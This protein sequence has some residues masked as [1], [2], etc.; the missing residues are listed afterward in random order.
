MMHKNGGALALATALACACK[1]SGGV[2]PIPE[3]DWQTQRVVANFELLTPW[4]LDLRNPAMSKEMSAVV[5][6]SRFLGHDQGNLTIQA[7]HI[8]YRPGVIANV[9]RSVAGDVAGIRALPGVSDVRHA[10]TPTRVSGFNGLEIT[11]TIQRQGRGS[12]DLRGVLVAHD[13]EFW[14][15]LVMFPSTDPVGIAAWQ[16]VRQSA[17]ISAP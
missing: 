8:A 1:G 13:N 9:E 2:A 7:A 5:L 17:R 4:P 6:E 16:R 12:L 10:T 3:S 15:I 14:Q 11:G